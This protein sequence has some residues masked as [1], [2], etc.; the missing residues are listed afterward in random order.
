MVYVITD[1]GDWAKIG[2]ANNVETRLRN[3]QTGNP[4]ALF[5]IITIYSGSKSRDFLL[6]QA[7]HERYKRH[8][9]SVGGVPSEWFLLNGIKE[10]VDATKD[11][12][13]GIVHSCGLKFTV[14]L[15]RKINPKDI[16][17]MFLADNNYLDYRTVACLRSQG[18]CG[19]R[20]LC[21]RME[22][23][24]DEVGFEISDI[25]E[26]REKRIREAVDAYFKDHKQ[27]A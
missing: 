20:E 5:V 23:H 24:S 25:G 19:I 16:P 17:I 13:N 4:R 14:D 18:I 6:E 27:S 15:N 1:G 7:L 8:R 22:K 11:E 9:I 10:L 2:I 12:V 26:R 21:E 3:L